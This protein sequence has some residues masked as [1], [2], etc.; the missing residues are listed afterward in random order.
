MAGAFIFALTNGVE[1][2]DATDL[3]DGHVVL[4]FKR[5][6]LCNESGLNNHVRS[7]EKNS[8]PLRRVYNMTL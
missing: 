7:S 8:L 4:K 6:P 5:P 2:N 1:D 3:V